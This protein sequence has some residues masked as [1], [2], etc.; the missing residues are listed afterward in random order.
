V[1]LNLS[2]NNLQGL[3]NMGKF[4]AK[5]QC[6]GS[7]EILKLS[8]CKLSDPELKQLSHGLKINKTLRVIDLS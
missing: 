6:A 1:S 5:S 7:L 8:N 3:S 4:L 2:G